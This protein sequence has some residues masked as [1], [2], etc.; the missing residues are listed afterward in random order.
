MKSLLNWNSLPVKWFYFSTCTLANVPNS[1][2]S[3]IELNSWFTKHKNCNRQKAVN[4]SSSD[5]NELTGSNWK[6]WQIQFIQKMQ[7]C[8][9]CESFVENQA[10]PV[11]HCTLSSAN[12]HLETLMF[13]SPKE[14]K[15]SKKRNHFTFLT[16]PFIRTFEIIQ[17]T[18]LHVLQFSEWKIK[19]ET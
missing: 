12:L 11:K 18:V 1:T 19:M 4:W 16:K 6:Y 8:K 13:L 15:N 7:F 3:L 14:S 10:E 9:N 5:W 2:I 17:I